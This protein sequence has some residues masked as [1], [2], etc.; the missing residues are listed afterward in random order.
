MMSTHRTEHMRPNEFRLVLDAAEPGETFVY[1]TGFIAWAMH[2]AKDHADLAALQLATYE[3][4]VKGNVALTQKRLAPFQ[5][6]YRATKRANGI[7]P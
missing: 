2:E 3:A 6:E 5:F 4:H 7:A 1:A